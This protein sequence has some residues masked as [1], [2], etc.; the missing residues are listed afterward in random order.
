MTTNKEPDHDGSLGT[1]K[2]GLQVSSS[3]KGWKGKVTARKI[4]DA[5]DSTE[6]LGI[7]F[8]TP[9]SCLGYEAVL[10]SGR[11]EI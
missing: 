2:A 7:H 6:H 3:S 4:E 9:S 1:P 11:Q 5:L 10:P 8:V